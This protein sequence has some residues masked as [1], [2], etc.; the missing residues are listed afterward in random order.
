MNTIGGVQVIETNVS[1]VSLLLI[2]KEIDV[3]LM[4]IILYT[5]YLNIIM[6]V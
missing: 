2:L 3:N 1:P 6:L 4:V 5:I